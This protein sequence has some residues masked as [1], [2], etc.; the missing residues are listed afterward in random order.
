MRRLGG[1]LIF[2]EPQMPLARSSCWIQSL[3]R[4]GAGAVRSASQHRGFT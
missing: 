3:S 2:A 4:V 1:D